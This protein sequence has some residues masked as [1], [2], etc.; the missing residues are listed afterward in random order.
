LNLLE[1]ELPLEIPVKHVKPIQA[2]DGEDQSVFAK[3]GKYSPS[4]EDGAYMVPPVVDSVMTQ[5]EKEMADFLPE[6]MLSMDLYA[7]SDEVFLQDLKE[8]ENLQFRGAYFAGNIK[9]ADKA[10]I[11]FFILNP[12]RKVIYN[13]RKQAEGIFSINATKPG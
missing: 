1:L 4:Q 7:K 10:H 13:R 2:I 3:K 8:G 5:M 12:D 11:D 9:E 6:K